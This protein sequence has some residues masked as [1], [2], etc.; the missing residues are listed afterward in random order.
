MTFVTHQISTHNDDPLVGVEVQWPRSCS[1][2]SMYSLAATVGIS[3]GRATPSANALKAWGQRDQRECFEEHPI[4]T[5][6]LQ[7]HARTIFFLCCKVSNQR[8]SSFGLF[9]TWT[10]SSHREVLDMEIRFFHER[11]IEKDPKLL[12]D[13]IQRMAS[14]EMPFFP[15]TLSL[16]FDKFVEKAFTISSPSSSGPGGYTKGRG[17]TH[18]TP[19]LQASTSAS[20]TTSSSS[21]GFA[22]AFHDLNDFIGGTIS[23]VT[24]DGPTWLRCEQCGGM[25]RL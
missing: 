19:S 10:P 23:P 3:C 18:P 14:G 2:R 20:R 8:F 16:A 6:H 1:P 4:R 15:T 12:I 21:V 11:V 22:A 5:L 7:R 25:T 24:T 9:L 13:C 17:L